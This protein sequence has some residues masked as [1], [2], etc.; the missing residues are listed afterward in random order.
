MII[1]KDNKSECVK[2]GMELENKFVE[3]YK[4]LGWEINPEKLEGNDLALDLWHRSTNRMGDLKTQETPFFTAKKKWPDIIT[5]CST[6]VSFNVKDYESYKNYPYRID[7]I[8]FHINW[9]KTEQLFGNRLYKVQP[10]NEVYEV[11]FKVVKKICDFEGKLS[12]RHKYG[13]S[14]GNFRPKGNAEESYVFDIQHPVIARYF[15]RV[16]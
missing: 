12:H 5:D 10:R 6:T 16:A 7:T 8:I 9:M 3:K 15:E 13:S 14:T 4:Y 2:Y 11:S 1:D